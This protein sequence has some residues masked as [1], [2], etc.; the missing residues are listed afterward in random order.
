MHSHRALP[1]RRGGAARDDELPAAP[2]PS[3]SRA[4]WRIAAADVSSNN[5]VRLLRDG[6]ATFD[7]MLELIEEARTSVALESYI[8]RSDEVGQQFADALVRAVARGVAVRL[9]LDW[10]GARGTARS[11]IRQLEKRGVDVQVFNPPGFRPW[12]GLV[13][14]DHRKLLVVDD[15]VG[16]TGGVGV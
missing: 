16:I 2:G 15:R 7:A 6:P 13:P 9:L 1:A 5:R 10:I 3:F 12:L 8:F 11:F 14:R 4:L